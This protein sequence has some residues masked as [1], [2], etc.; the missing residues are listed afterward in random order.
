LTYEYGLFGI[1]VVFTIDNIDTPYLNYRLLPKQTINRDFIS[2]MVAHEKDLSL[3][4]AKYYDTSFSLRYTNLDKVCLI[5]EL[6]S[7]KEEI[8]EETA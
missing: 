4:L 3:F 2:D 1:D 8:E 7:V 5:K 6:A